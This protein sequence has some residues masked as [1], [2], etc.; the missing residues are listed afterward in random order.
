MKDDEGRQTT[1]SVS[2]LTL[3]DTFQNAFVLDL[4]RIIVSAEN[5]YHWT[6]FDESPRT[7]A[8]TNYD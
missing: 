7:H 5:V 4:V 6:E 3:D 2:P 8:S 1:R